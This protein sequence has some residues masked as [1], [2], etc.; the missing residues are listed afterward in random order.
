MTAQRDK[1]LAISDHD[2]ASSNRFLLSSADSLTAC[3]INTFRFQYG[4]GPYLRES[5]EVQ[6]KIPTGPI[7]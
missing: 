2:G 7:R 1:K 5:E 6:R 3:T 4:W